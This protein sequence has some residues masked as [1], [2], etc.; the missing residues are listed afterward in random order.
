MID[1]D[2]KR[3]EL[4]LDLLQ[5]NKNE[6][7]EQ[8]NTLDQKCSS[9][10]NILILIITIQCGIYA[11]VS[12]LNEIAS[13]NLAIIIKVLLIITLLGNFIALYLFIDAYYLKD[14]KGM[15]NEED[16]I[17]YGENNINLETIYKEISVDYKKTIE[18]NKTELSKKI[19]KIKIG[20]KL[21]TLTTGIFVF[22]II[23]C[24]EILI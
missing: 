19:D 24:L 2:N 22:T 3:Y 11:N 14:F 16:I 23:I 6:Q 18:E 17:K 7:D 21:V 10:I 12:L 5:K 4:L 15:T 8:N 9:M 1:T 13:N 20:F